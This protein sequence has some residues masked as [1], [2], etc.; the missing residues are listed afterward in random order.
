LFCE[1]DGSRLIQPVDRRPAISGTDM[2]A[3]IGTFWREQAVEHGP[4]LANFWHRNKILVLLTIVP[5]VPWLLAIIFGIRFGDEVLVPALGLILVAAIS[6]PIALMRSE[7]ALDGVYRMDAWFERSANYLRSSDGKF[8]RWVVYPIVWLASKFM[9]L[10]H[11]APDPFAAAAVR[12]YCYIAT[13]TIVLSIVAFT[14][15][16]FLAL[17]AIGVCLAILSA[18]MGDGPSM[19]DFGKQAG[20]K[21]AMRAVR[22]TEKEQKLF[23]GG[24]WWSDQRT[25]RV[26]EDGNI[27]EGS[28]FWNEKRVGRV[29]EDGKI[30]EGSSRW[31]DERVGR[32]DE[33]GRVYEGNSAWTDQRTGRIDE[34]GKVYKGTSAWT[35]ER[36]GRIEED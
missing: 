22:R 5:V 28:S 20:K 24:S 1:N 29:D 9:L 3:A 31:A 8:R 4:G 10:S 16:L 33:E 26:D 23:E 32:V 35:D 7:K 36:S 18:V 11:K 13:V 19:P 30:Y 27:Y 21:L 17:L 34:D 25:G 15:M 12:V 6:W 14:I 2:A